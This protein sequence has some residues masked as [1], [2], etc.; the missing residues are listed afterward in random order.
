M[1]DNTYILGAGITGLSAGFISGFPV[2]E[3][4]G[5]PGGICSS[6]YL[7]PGSNET[8]PQRP[9]ND[10]NAYRFEFGGGH[11]IFGCDSNLTEFLNKFVTLKD[12]KRISSVFF[13]KTNTY[14]PYPIQNH[15]RFLESS[16]A[17]QAIL[18]MSQQGKTYRTMKEWQQQVFGSTLCDIFFFPFHKLYTASLFDR[19]A[20]QDSFKSPVNLS[21]VTKGAS[22]STSPTGYNVLFAYPDHGLDTL[23]RKISEKCNIIYNKHVINIDIHN[24]EILFS[25]SERIYYDR[26]ISTL[27][28]N[29]MI[30]ITGLECNR[31]PDPYTSVL[32]LNIGATRGD[33]CPND[34]WI[35]I[36]DSK[37]GFHRVGF[38]SNVDHSFLPKLYRNEY[39]KVSLY[40][41]RAFPGGF[42]PSRE[43]IHR[44][45][46]NVIKEL[47]E[48]HF[49]KDLEAMDSTWIDVAYTWSWPGSDWKNLA[50]SKLKEHGIFQTGRYGKW[51][52]QGIADSIRNGFSVPNLLREYQ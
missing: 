32:V 50:I 31:E 26:L 16:I 39:S 9:V 27:P 25:D 35:Y 41:E 48:W 29:K 22:E 8:L 11:W 30:E 24:K 21:Q 18:E 13:H 3:S 19:I 6:Y 51:S 1:S 44:Y 42:K 33:K 37:S 47:Q 4:K 10:G 28:L 14:I 40:I 20:P 7:I 49:I 2:F 23:A 46:N 34:H 17:N 43:S 45:A 15:L 12:Y 52:F 5:Y 36:P 38:Y